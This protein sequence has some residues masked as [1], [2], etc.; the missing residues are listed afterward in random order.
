ML[1]LFSALICLAV[2]S[3]NLFVLCHLLQ[4][5]LHAWLSLAH[6]P[7]AICMVLLSMC[8]DVDVFRSVNMDEE[9]CDLV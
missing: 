4:V 2:N 6:G 7:W 1:V 5:A 9:A 8:M 3:S